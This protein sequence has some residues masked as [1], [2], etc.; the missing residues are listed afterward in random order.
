[1][2]Q[3]RDST[4]YLRLHT[5]WLQCY[6]DLYRFLVPGLRESVSSQAMSNT[7]EDYIFYC[8]QSILAKVT[9]LC[10][11]WTK[12]FDSS[13]AEKINDIFLGISCYQVSQ[14]IDKLQHVLIRNHAFENLDKIKCSLRKTLDMVDPAVCGRFVRLEGCLRE[15]ELVVQRLGQGNAEAHLPQSQPKS[16]GNQHHLISKGSM[17]PRD[18][19]ESDE[20]THP[21][22]QS[23]LS[24]QPEQHSIS[25]SH[26]KTSDLVPG[27]GLAPEAQSSGADLM[28]SRFEGLGMLDFG[29]IQHDFV[30]WDSL[31]MELPHDYDPELGMLGLYT[32]I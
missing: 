15:A 11:T 29:E 6:C 10:D 8:Q 21:E 31:S 13:P 23:H 25:L 3:S 22:P 2:A 20:T 9:Y 19:S 12:F 1:M 14:I 24:E 26:R 18:S 5:V 30:E 17:I 32:R 4:A 16:Y 7:P 28:G 27:A